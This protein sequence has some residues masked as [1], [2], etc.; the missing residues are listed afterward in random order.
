MPVI[1]YTAIID[2]KITIEL[3]KS[4]KCKFIEK[5]MPVSLLLKALNGI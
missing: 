4:D 3:E 5:S 2:P 1:F